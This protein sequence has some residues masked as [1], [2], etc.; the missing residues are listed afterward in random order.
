MNTAVAVT[1]G[2]LPDEVLAVVLRFCD[3]RKRMM[4]IA[5]VSRQWLGVC[6][7]LMRHPAIDLA[8]A[9]RHHSWPSPTP[10]SPGW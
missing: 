2:S 3:A 6:H 5:A 8:W 4:A 10:G 9:V 1:L 7:H